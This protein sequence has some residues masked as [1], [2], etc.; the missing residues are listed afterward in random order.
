M[1][2]FVFGDCVEIVCNHLGNTYVYYPKSNETFN[3]DKGGVRGND[4]TNQVTS[5]GQNMRQLNMAKW[6]IDG[7][8]AVDQISDL[9]LSTLNLMAGSPSEGIWQFSMRNGV[10][11]K[12]KG[13]PVGD[14][15]ADSNA[16][17]LTLK[18]AGGGILEKI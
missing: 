3:I 10:I 18:V 17:T 8:I 14:I 7:P 13:A 2:N 16:G 11:Y 1:A 4:D 6:S 9:E 12:G 5:N 15:T